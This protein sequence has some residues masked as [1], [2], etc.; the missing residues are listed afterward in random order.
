MA[1]RA[2]ASIF[3]NSIN[4]STIV[5]EDFEGDSRY[6]I[7]AGINSVTAILLFL[8]SVYLS[9]RLR[10]RAWNTI[11]KRFSRIL[12][13]VNVLPYLLPLTIVCGFSGSCVFSSSFVYLIYFPVVSTF[14][15]TISATALMLQVMFP[16]L[17]EGKKRCLQSNAVTKCKLILEITAV[18]MIV[19]YNICLISFLFNFLSY[20]IILI[21]VL[22]LLFSLTSFIIQIFSIICLLLF[23]CKTVRLRT[24][25][26][27]LWIK[28]FL[29]ATIV[30][31][32]SIISA[33]SFIVN[34]TTCILN[35]NCTSPV[36]GSIANFV[37]IFVLVTIVTV[38]TYPREVW[39]CCYR[40]PA[41]PNVRTPLL[42]NTA[43][44]QETNP[45]SVWDHRNDPSTTATNYPPEMTDCRSDYEQLLSG[46]VVERQYTRSLGGSR[47]GSTTYDLLEMSDCRPDYR[48]L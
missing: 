28:L 11:S 42:I 4:S 1:A 29:L 21:Q 35:G 33:V 18:I 9:V 30:V 31:L 26:K 22:L 27:R 25:T 32:D 43:E 13:I 10:K 7:A 40:R 44:G 20:I 23:G 15:I 47:S 34:L 38:L 39:C 46:R 8:F 12:E 3:T 16:W 41:N 2:S 6:F 45:V 37:C 36:F 14:C 19:V 48:P 17:P 5:S 24:S